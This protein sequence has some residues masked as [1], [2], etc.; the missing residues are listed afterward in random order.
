MRV[1]SDRLL[2]LSRVISR[3][4]KENANLIQKAD[5]ETVRRA[6]TRALTESHRELEAIEEKVR[7]SL[8]KRKAVSPRDLDFLFNK[9]L[10][11]ELERHGA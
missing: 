1:S 4:L 5:E 3:K 11:E 6:V 10:E 2:Y 8:S 9:R 7:A